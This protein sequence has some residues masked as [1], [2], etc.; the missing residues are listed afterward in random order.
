M[1]SHN[2]IFLLFLPEDQT[3]TQSHHHLFIKYFFL[4]KII[5]A[6]FSELHFEYLKAVETDTAKLPS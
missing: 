6:V 5:H 1:D 3:Q 4:I 2:C